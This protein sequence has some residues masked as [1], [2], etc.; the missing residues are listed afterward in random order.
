MSAPLRDPNGL[1]KLPVTRDWLERFR[2]HAQRQLRASL[3]GSQLN[4]RQGQSRDFL[5]LA[6]Y[7]PGDDA[8]TIDWRASLR[9]KQSADLLVRRY[10]AEQHYKLVISVDT[11]DTLLLPLDLPKVQ[12]ALWLAEAIGWMA[13]RSGH[14]VAIH[15]LFGPR[16]GSI[17]QFKGAQAGSRLA[18]ALRG[19]YQTPVD[20]EAPNLADLDHILP[21]AA[22]WLIL[23]DLYF[24]D[25]AHAA[26]HY[27][28]EHAHKL[29]Q[30]IV[31]AQAGW[32]WIILLDI[33]SWEFE[34]SRLRG[35]RALE[36]EGYGLPPGRYLQ[37]VDSAVWD[38][39]AAA[40]GSFKQRFMEL[41]RLRSGS[42]V[43][44]VYPQADARRPD[45]APSLVRE[46]LQRQPVL[47]RLF[48]EET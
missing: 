14:Q 17:R 44:C 31:Q 1:R 26:E 32:R 34:K 41:A 24:G 36:I 16:A 27:A 42:L 13:L 8:R 37:E 29:A 3:V 23:T 11:R 6:P 48:M 22:I 21:P 28:G 18:A 7:V 2:L 46:V 30:R 19:F 10:M 47:K 43:H 38:A 4:R 35:E 9:Y 40:V 25:A 5:E 39:K 12:L 20:D 33:D 15:R 45:Y